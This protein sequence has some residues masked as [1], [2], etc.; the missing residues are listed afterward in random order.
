[1]RF[2]RFC[3]QHNEKIFSVFSVRWV[4]I[5]VWFCQIMPS[6]SLLAAPGHAGLRQADAKTCFNCHKDL[7]APPDKGSAHL[8]FASGECTTCH[9]L[10]EDNTFKIVNTGGV[11]CYMCHEPKNTKAVVHGPVASGDCTLCH[12]PHQSPNP[13]LLLASPVSKLCF[14]CHDEAMAKHK[15]VHVPVAG[16]PMAAG[17]CL[18]CHDPHESP[19]AKQLV[20]EGKGLCLMCHADKE[21]Q[22]KKKHVHAAIDMVGCTGCH[23]PHST[24]NKHQLLKAVPDLCYDCHSD[25]KEEVKTPHEAFKVQKSCVNCHDPHASDYDKQLKAEENMELCL[26][27]HNRVRK[28]SRGYVMNMK[29][30]LKDNPDHHGPILMGDCAVCHNPHGSNNWRM[31]R[32]AFPSEFYAEFKVEKYSLCFECHDKELALEKRTSSATD[33]RNGDKNLHYVH[34][35]SPRKGRTCVVCHN[36]HAAKDPKHI[37]ESAKFGN[38]EIPINFEI[39][40]N[41]GR[42]APGCHFPVAYNRS[43]SVKKP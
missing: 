14:A 21:E 22:L 27:C 32:K 35:N 33:F 1:M 25:K 17:E 34:V 43:E 20:Q 6:G 30:W 16:G 18:S 5:F 2:P 26:K 41:G 9:E 4:I 39:N 11:L 31:L 15:F 38:W 23:S 37:R 3:P 42:C 13:K 19:Y 8:P 10:K 12:S 29:K 7:A 28:T 24:D 36:I 40:E